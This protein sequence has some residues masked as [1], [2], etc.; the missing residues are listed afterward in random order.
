[1]L[2]LAQVLE[3][4]PSSVVDSVPASALTQPV[5]GVTSDSRQV[6]PGWIFVAVRGDAKDGHLFIEVAARQGALAIVCEAPSSEVLSVP[7][8]VVPDSRAALA[9]LAANFHGRP[10]EKLLMVG[11]TGT[12]GKTTTTYLIESILRAAG[13]NPGVI[14]TVNFRYAGKVLEATHTTPGALELQKLLADM[15]TAGCDS[16]VMEVSSHA[17]KQHR[18]GDIAFD[19]MV[20]ANLTPEHL[21]FHP[22][23]DD[24]FNSK[25]RLFAELAEFSRK[26]G[27][28]PFAAING[29]DDYGKRLVSEIK[30]SRLKWEAYSVPP[31]WTCGLDGVRGTLGAL[32]IQS[33]LTGRFNASNILAAVKVARG[34]GIP[35]AAIERGISELP[36]VPGR[37]ERV[38][39]SRGIHVL[40]DY[41]HKPDALEKVLKTLVEV[42]GKNKLITVFGCG[43]DRD[44]T[45]RPVMGKMAVEFSDYVVVTSDNPRTESPQS[46]IDEILKGIA[47]AP[48]GARYSVEVDRKEAIALA[49]NE[50]KP[51]DIVLIAGK[52]HEDYQIIA[53]PKAEKGMRKIHFDDRE[54]AAEAL[55][56]KSD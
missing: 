42:R 41:A 12:S 39:N 22:D 23:M 11:V 34:L 55:G 18:V 19:G 30:S 52:G 17:L 15:R 37:L 3:G 33:S 40:V 14:G 56:S 21:D 10:S 50:A 43:G 25:K 7:V 26:R 9:T 4:F 29:E 46:I 20:F 32:K 44:R 38:P 51:G 27:K 45:K 54:V 2:N 48:K 53:D 36:V 35:D 13:K 24:Y 31:T 1:M 5:L 8:L 28:K 6:A 49:I 16:V 47:Q